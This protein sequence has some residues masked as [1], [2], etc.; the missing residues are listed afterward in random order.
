M[1]NKYLIVQRF[2]H[3][4]QNNNFNVKTFS[5]AVPN[6]D[7]PAQIYLDLPMGNIRENIITFWLFMLQGPE[8]LQKEFITAGNIPDLKAPTADTTVFEWFDNNTPQTRQGLIALATFI[9]KGIY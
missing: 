9:E 7:Q 6:T 4:T 2:A 5:T 8:K 3:Q 1:Q